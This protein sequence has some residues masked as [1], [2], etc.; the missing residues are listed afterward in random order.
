MITAAQKREFYQA[1]VNKDPC[2]KGVF[3]V[4]VKTTM[5]FCQPTCPARKP[6]F[7]NCVFYETAEEALR[8]SFRECKRCRPISSPN[9]ESDL[10]RKLV[11][12]IE[13]DPCRR[14]DKRDFRDLLVDESTVRRQFKRRFGM[15]FVQYARARK[16][17]VAVEQ[18]RTGDSII[19][20]QLNTGY[21]SS[22]GFRDA[23]SKIIGS[24]P[25]KFDPGSEVLKVSWFDTRLGIMIAVSD[26][27]G[28]YLLEFADIPSLERKLERLRFKARSAIIP[29]NTLH[30]ETIRLE[31][32]SYFAGT[33]REFKTPIHLSGTPFQKVAWEAL[34]GIPYGDTRSYRA[35]AASIGKEGAYRAV[36]N[37]NG[38]NQIAIVIP[39]HRIIHSNGDIGGYAAGTARKQ[40]LINHERSAKGQ[41]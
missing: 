37:A 16:M 3:L 32:Q 41:I 20:I 4:G 13:A 33:L 29:G 34:M 1:F 8:E 31:L 21:E 11:E 12:A 15:T 36:A 22:S 14:W 23:F 30:S 25:G 27:K 9:Q 39:C 38:A 2:Y 35:Q 17:G 7:E 19:D 24:A 18:I 26:D 6:K 5:V 28:I 10:V 40:W